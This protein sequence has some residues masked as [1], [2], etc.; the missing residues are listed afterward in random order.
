MGTPKWAVRVIL[1]PPE[2]NVF[3]IVGANQ[4]ILVY[5]AYHFFKNDF[6]NTVAHKS[7]VVHCINNFLFCL[8]KRES[9]FKFTLIWF[10]FTSNRHN[11]T[12]VRYYFIEYTS[13]WPSVLLASVNPAAGGQYWQ[14]THQP[15]S[16]T[17]CSIL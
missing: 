4:R 16:N 2:K 14:A 15:L 17:L 5:G 10:F 11:M 3:Q 6:Q 7:G 8:R 13:L 1:N 9:P 12:S